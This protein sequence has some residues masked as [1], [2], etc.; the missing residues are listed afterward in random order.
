MV[1]DN[2]NVLGALIAPRKTDA[3]SII[4]PNAV[5]PIAIAVER[6]QAIA[7]RN[8]QLIKPRYRI[9]PVELPPSNVP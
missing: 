9:D 2:L 1:I 5:L 7:R 4:N 8:P 3:V 6:F